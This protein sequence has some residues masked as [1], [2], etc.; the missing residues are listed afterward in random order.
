M[1]HAKDIKV[2]IDGRAF[3]ALGVLTVPPE[4]DLSKAT[5]AVICQAIFEKFGARPFIGDDV[6]T[7]NPNAIRE[8]DVNAWLAACGR[9]HL[10]FRHFVHDQFELEEVKP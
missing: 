10:R 6:R 7:T 4:P 8:R 2:T 5:N 1:I 3:E 9:P